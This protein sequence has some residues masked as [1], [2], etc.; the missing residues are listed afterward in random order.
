MGIGALDAAPGVSASTEA[1]SMDSNLLLQTG[2]RMQVSCVEIPCI[3]NS[4]LPLHILH[5]RRSTRGSASSSATTS[6]LL[7]CLAN[8]RGVLPPYT[9]GRV[10]GA[11]MQVNRLSIRF[12]ITRSL[13][14]PLLADPPYPETVTLC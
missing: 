1:E 2:R 14:V 5:Q 4:S 8:M 6:A 7:D 9:K 10:E 13:Y 12:T 3:G 11:T